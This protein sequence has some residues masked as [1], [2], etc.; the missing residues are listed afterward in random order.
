[1]NNFTVSYRYSEKYITFGSCYH[2]ASTVWQDVLHNGE[3][4]AALSQ[5]RKGLL[6]PIEMSFVK[7]APAN[8]A[9]KFDR[10]FHA[11]DEGRVMGIFEGLEDG[12]TKLINYLNNN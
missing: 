11:E 7:N 5:R 4:V 1:M 2:T 10:T 6:Q 8:H 3:I 12:L 9:D